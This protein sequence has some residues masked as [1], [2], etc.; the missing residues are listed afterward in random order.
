MGFVLLQEKKF[1]FPVAYFHDMIVTDNWYILFDCPIK[2]SLWKTFVQYP[3]GKVGLGDTISEDMDNPP[4]FRLFPRRTD[5]EMIVIPAEDIHCYAY[6]H[7]NGFDVDEKGHKIIFDTCTWDRFT[8]YFKDIVEPDGEKCFPR[9][10]LTRFEIDVEEGVAK[11]RTLN[12]RP[13]EY[14][15]VSPEVSGRPYLHSYMS[16]SY[17]KEGGV[18]G[19]MQSLTKMTL[20]SKSPGAS[21]Q[22]ENWMPGDQKFVGEPILVT[23]QNAQKEDDAWVLILVHDG[24]TVSTEL[25]ILDASKLSEGPVATLKLPAYVPMGVHGS[26]ASEYILGPN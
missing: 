22:E 11:H 19:P 20:E 26:W 3:L 13:C 17:Y 1:E 6:H 15:A 5:G 12:E 16:T 10:K 21:A 24:A 4:L 8:L 2:M 14:P 23:K 18:Y 9:T 25:A 7:V